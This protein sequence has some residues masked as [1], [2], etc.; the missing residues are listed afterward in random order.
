M[1]K[2]KKVSFFLENKICD[3]YVLKMILWFVKVKITITPFLIIP[4]SINNVD[5]TA[6]HLSRY[7]QFY[8]K[9]LVKMSFCFKAKKP[10]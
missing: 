3:I 9:N 5:E 6:N 10:L 8:I 7:L 4:P 2:K 1:K